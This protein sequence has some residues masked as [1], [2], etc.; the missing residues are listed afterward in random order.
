MN[1]ISQRSSKVL[2]AL[3][4]AAATVLSGCAATGGALTGTGATGSAARTRP[5]VGV[6][7]PSGYVVCSGGRASRFPEREADGRVCRDSIS[8]QAIY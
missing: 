5:P 2:G 1:T 8:L 7:A 6:T 4:V 3:V